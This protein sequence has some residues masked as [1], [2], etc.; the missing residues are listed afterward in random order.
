MKESIQHKL[1]AVR[2]R[3]EELEGLLAEPDVIND[4]NRYRDL[5]Q[6]YARIGPVVTLF[7]DF[8]A[9]QTDITAA[10]EMAADSDPEVRE[11]GQEELQAATSR[12][13]ELELELQKSLI[14]PD[15][16]DSSNVY[17]EVRA[18]TGRA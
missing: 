5:S 1:E 15:P 17:L 14:P 9:L 7:A 16:H 12:S 18:G 13:E 6:E 3:H 10:E 4:Q 2:D 11:M 8:L